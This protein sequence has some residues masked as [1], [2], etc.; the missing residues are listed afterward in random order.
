MT[1][2]IHSII[3]LL[4]FTVSVQAESNLIRA[5]FSILSKKNNEISVSEADKT[6]QTSKIRD[7]TEMD[8]FST[9]HG[10]SA[11][12][13]RDLGLKT[14]NDDPT[15][16][17]KIIRKTI[18]KSEFY[19]SNGGFLR[20]AEHFN[21]LMNVLYEN[22]HLQKYVDEDFED[23]FEWSKIVRAP[24][25]APTFKSILDD[26]N[27]I[28]ENGKYVINPDLDIR[29]HKE[30]GII[31]NPLAEVLIKKILPDLTEDIRS[32]S[33]D[34]RF[35]ISAKVAEGLIR[36]N[37]ELY[38]KKELEIIKSDPRAYAVFVFAQAD[39][40][41]EYFA[42]LTTLSKKRSIA[43]H[44][45][46]ILNL[47][48]FVSLVYF[49]PFLETVQYGPFAGN[50]L[51]YVMQ[52]AA[53]YF[54]GKY[55]ISKTFNGLMHARAKM[56]RWFYKF[57][58]DKFKSNNDLYVSIDERISLE[59]KRLIDLASNGAQSHLVESD[60]DS[61]LKG[62]LKTAFILHQQQ[63]NNLQ[64]SASLLNK[65]EEYLDNSNVNWNNI[66]NDLDF[67]ELFYYIGKDINALENS[68][69]QLKEIKNRISSLERNDSSLQNS[70]I[71]SSLNYVERLENL[72]KAQKD[73]AHAINE[74]NG[75]LNT[76]D[77][78]LD[79]LVQITK[80][81]NNRIILSNRNWIQLILAN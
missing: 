54:I 64:K 66:N 35:L 17:K 27:V 71:R 44:L 80:F 76:K 3:I 74:F 43:I 11:K 78:Y 29:E 19:N 60:T 18:V 53:P 1:L 5:C 8:T 30:K 32:M 56:K 6:A 2:R 48:N 12:E 57:N 26:N 62:I 75:K 38:F 61:P 41:G 40:I 63:S 28:F 10:L 34:E 31:V 42:T 37:N 14:I 59:N 68:I 25:E 39:Y 21:I 52:I 72:L 36:Q 73:L 55:T 9:H 81:E 79:L 13:A 22:G 49:T 7:F 16:A 50:L 23:N 33:F 15:F 69:E 77:D 51:V 70:Q 45:E 4:S 58:F 47:T 65:T 20:V 67:D 24:Y 46:K